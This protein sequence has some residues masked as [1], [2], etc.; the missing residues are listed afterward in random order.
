MNTRLPLWTLPLVLTPALATAQA[1]TSS[2]AMPEH[3]GPLPRADMPLGGR[4]DPAP[5]GNDEGTPPRP[6]VDLPPGFPRPDGLRLEWGGYMRV[7]GELS[8]NDDL[9]AIGRNDGFRLANVRLGLRASWGQKLYGYVSLDAA[10]AAVSSADDTNAE[11][12][13]GLRDAYIAYELAPAATIQ[14]GRFKPPFDLVE[15]EATEGRVFIDEAIESRGVL[16]TQGIEA[17]G[18]RP[19]RQMGLMI[20]S[21][22][23]GLGDGFDLGY[24]L[25]ITNGNTG[26]RVFNDN[27]H[28]AGFARLSGLFGKFLAVNAAG[29]IDTRTSGTQPDLFEDRVIGV[30]GSLAF[31]ME[32]LRVEGQF[33]FQH[34]DPLSAV[35]PAFDSMGWHAQWSYRI[36]GLEP[37]YRYAWFDPNSN[38]ELDIVQEHT[39]ALSYY[40]DPWPLRVSL[41]GTFA[42]EERELDNHRLALLVQYTF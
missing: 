9:L 13:V 21:P 33:L 2:V 41:N 35:I 7:I 37:A 5:G 22:R 11:L 1:T 40:V 8:Q 23:V 20:H 32:G 30:E 36:W 19:G 10:V 25:A 28:F 42:F 31:E 26:D 17:I 6:H 29:F 4:P 38:S 24:A 18:M 39:V 3:G 27:D 12:A 16:R 34:D 14:I 15:L